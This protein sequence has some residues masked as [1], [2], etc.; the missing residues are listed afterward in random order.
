MILFK[1][2]VISNDFLKIKGFNLLRGLKESH[3]ENKAKF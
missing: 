3:I 1:L 2:K